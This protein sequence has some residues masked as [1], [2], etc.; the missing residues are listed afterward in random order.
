SREL[1]RDLS[2]EQALELIDKIIEYYKANA[3]P[4]QRLGALIEKM[5]FEQFKS[6]VLGE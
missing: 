1:V 2:E 3:K 5:G 4:R 6:A